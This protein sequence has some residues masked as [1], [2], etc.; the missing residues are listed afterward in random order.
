MPR[1]KNF[2]NLS[3]NDG[4]KA[5]LMI[6]GEIGSGWFSEITGE[7]IN[8]ELKLIGDV[9]E[10]DVRIHSPG[11]SVFEGVAIYNALKNHKAKINVIIDGYCAS[12]ATVI[13]MA[14]DTIVMGLGTIFMVHNPLTF[15]QGN[16]D[17]LTK[18]A[19]TLNVLGENMIDI[20]MTKFNGTRAEMKAMMDAETWLDPQSALDKGFINQIGKFKMKDDIV[21]LDMSHFKNFNKFME[22]NKP[23]D[24]GNEMLK[25][26]A[27]IKSF[28]EN[29]KKEK[30][31]IK[32]TKEQF[33]KE[34]PEMFKDILAEGVSQERARIE[35]LDSIEAT[36]EEGRLIIANAKFKEPKSAGEV[37]LAIL[38]AKPTA[39]TQEKP[40]AQTGFQAHFEA[41]KEEAKIVATLG[42]VEMTAEQIEK[43][44]EDDY[45]AQMIGKIK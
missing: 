4:K 29:D 24:K 13:A 26:L 10:I 7:T 8:E 5:E 6:Y 25:M 45:I 21:A 36:S 42:N 43:Q 23:E 1:S 17:E 19:E 39:V 16:A 32:M 31:K 11:G 35:E 41:K 44:K 18:M 2:Y 30:E 38:K 15:I 14:G 12:I 40:V 37:A 22:K 20:Y 27:S 9:E 28:F 3:K 34:Q 33:K